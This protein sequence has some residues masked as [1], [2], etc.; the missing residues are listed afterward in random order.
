LVGQTVHAQGVRS[1]RIVNRLGIATSNALRFTIG[2]HVSAQVS[3]LEG[4]ELLLGL[5]LDGGIRQ[6]GFSPVFQL[7]TR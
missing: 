3:M 4:P 5:G 6:I 7:D 2:A 1:D